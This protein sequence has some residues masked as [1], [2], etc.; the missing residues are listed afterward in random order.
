MPEQLFPLIKEIFGISYPDKTPVR[1]LGTEFSVERSDT[2]KI[3]SI[4]ADVTLL[5]G[6]C[7]IYHFECESRRDK[8]MVMRMFEYD[9]HIALSYRE[10]DASLRFP[11]SAV[12]SLPDGPDAPNFLCCRI[13]LPNK[14]SYDYKVPSVRVQAYSLKD[15]RQKHLSVLIPFLPL[16]FRKYSRPSRKKRQISKEALT[17]FYEE[18]ILILESEVNCGYLSENGRS[19]ILSLL[20]KSFIRIFE[21]DESLRKEVIAMT[22]PLLE[23]EIEK[24]IYALEDAERFRDQA[25]KELAKKDTEIAALKKQLARLQSGQPSP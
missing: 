10:Q 17:S 15:I 7:D 9:A 1:P 22:E 2:K 13:H 14:S 24:Y 25:Q 3:T 20:S 18:I 11:Y 23:L 4:R 6:K 19:V 5:V 8:N 12:L 21:H 16:R